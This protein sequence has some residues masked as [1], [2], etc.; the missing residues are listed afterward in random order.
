MSH[1]ERSVICRHCQ[2][3][4]DRGF[5]WNFSDTVRVCF[6]CYRVMGEDARKSYE[7]TAARAESKK[8]GSGS[9]GIRSARKAMGILALLIVILGAVACFLY[10]PLNREI[11]E[12]RVWA[13]ESASAKKQVEFHIHL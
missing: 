5:I 9:K 13:G 4:H 3:A 7:R 11:A 8:A 12:Q 2:K 10:K 6:T 1:V